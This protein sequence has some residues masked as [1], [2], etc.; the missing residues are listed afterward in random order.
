MTRSTSIF[1]TLILLATLPLPAFCDVEKEV[2]IPEF[3]LDTIA[4]E[5][6]PSV[7][8]LAKQPFIITFWRLGQQYSMDALEDL[9]R[10]HDEF[11][12]S[13]LSVIGICVGPRDT[14]RVQAVAEQLGIKFT[15]LI[16]V[17]RSVF[18]SFG[19]FVYPAT[20][21]GDKHG[22]LRFYRPSYTSEFLEDTRLDVALLLGK[23]NLQQHTAKQ[24]TSRSAQE[25]LSFA[26]TARY[27]MG[28]RLLRKG[29]FKEAKA[30][31]RLSWQENP[32]SVSA[33]VELG[34]LLLKDEANAEALAVLS[35]T[36][37][38]CPNSARAQ[39]GYAVALI[40]SGHLDQGK[41][42]LE[43]ILSEH[44]AEP[45]LYYEM[46]RLKEEEGA[47]DIALTYY[48]QGLALALGE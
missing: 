41:A 19:A 9:K 22:V 34:Y 42:L 45:F 40:R 12:E 24:S 47:R 33:G 31:F 30:Q 5:S 2:R 10:L 3:T 37:E 26:S 6:F 23:I 21:I 4:G 36:A 32:R 39:G 11:G 20:Y 1:L 29:D 43:R 13:G 15:L 44:P 46:G 17:D 16:D 8:K 27:N 28:L 14:D 48:K 7:D 18:S 25:D 35:E 38:L